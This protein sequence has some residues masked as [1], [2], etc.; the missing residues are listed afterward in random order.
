MYRKKHSISVVSGI[1]WGSWK[2][3][4]ADKGELLYINV[5]LLSKRLRAQMSPR[6]LPICQSIFILTPHPSFP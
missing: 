6:Y 4:P 5:F 1:Q 2:I 3:S